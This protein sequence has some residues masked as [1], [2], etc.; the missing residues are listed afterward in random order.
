LIVDHGWPIARVAERY[1]VSWPTVKRW[2]IRHLQV[3]TDPGPDAG[4]MPMLELP[5]L[6]ATDYRAFL[7]RLA[8]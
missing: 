7:H 1:D 4:H 6:A 8:R 3:R 5:R 2:A